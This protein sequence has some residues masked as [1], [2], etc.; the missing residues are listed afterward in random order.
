[1]LLFD[2]S[3]LQLANQELNGGEDDQ[4]ED[5]DSDS[6]PNVSIRLVPT[7]TSVCEF[8]RPLKQLN[9]SYKPTNNDF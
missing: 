5:D 1:M 7:D 4:I 3:E 6:A 8:F 2:V 9:L